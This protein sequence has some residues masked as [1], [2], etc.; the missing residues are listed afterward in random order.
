M[1]TLVP[2]TSGRHFDEARDLL[3][4]VELQRSTAWTLAELFLIFTG[5]CLQL[6]GL[7]WGGLLIGAALGLGLSRYGPHWWPGKR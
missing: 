5:A 2:P 1:L 6:A 4:F 3:D 7:P